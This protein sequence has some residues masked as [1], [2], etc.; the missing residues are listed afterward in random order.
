MANAGHY[1]RLSSTR[2]RRRVIDLAS[3]SPTPM[4]T[5]PPGLLS[6]WP[7]APSRGSG[8]EAV[9][10]Y[11]FGAAE[12]YPSRRGPARL[13]G[14]VCAARPPPRPHP[15][16]RHAALPFATW[17]RRR[18]VEPRPG[19]GSRCASS[20]RGIDAGAL[21]SIVSAPSSGRWPTSN[22]TSAAALPGHRDA[23]LRRTQPAAAS[24]AAPQSPS[25][26]IGG[27]GR[28]SPGRRCHPPVGPPR[29]GWSYATPALSG[30]LRPTPLAL[31]SPDVTYSLRWPPLHPSGPTWACTS[32]HAVDLLQV[33]RR[34]RPPRYVERRV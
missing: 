23:R 12:M 15:T 31:F 34:G 6:S 29:P 28:A 18:R 8:S 14:E 4:P 21:K 2:P 7:R 22:A 33:D 13:A 9:T 10:A 25:S 32:G 30:L 26:H 17:P 24:R 27:T 20:R 1:A 3:N 11:A 5:R 16:C 19:W